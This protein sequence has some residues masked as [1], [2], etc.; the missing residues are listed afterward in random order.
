MSSGNRHPSVTLQYGECEKDV[1]SSQI[2]FKQVSSRSEKGPASSSSHD[3]LGICP[4]V[5]YRPNMKDKMR[6]VGLESKGSKKRGGIRRHWS[7][8]ADMPENQGRF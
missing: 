2:P 5:V 1:I 7:C 8:I 4:L 6:V 3:D